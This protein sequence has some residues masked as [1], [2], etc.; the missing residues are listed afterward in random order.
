M[1]SYSCIIKGVSQR[2]PLS[3]FSF[4]KQGT[5]S[6]GSSAHSHIH[7]VPLVGFSG[8]QILFEAV[9]R[10]SGS[11]YS[12]DNRRDPR[13]HRCQRHFEDSENSKELLTEIEDKEQKK[14]Y[15]T[16]L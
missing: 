5:L 12:P 1:D 10:P 13:T 9:I 16:I 11:L 4:W 3:V 15:L 6:C 7:E 8:I 14:I 2:Q